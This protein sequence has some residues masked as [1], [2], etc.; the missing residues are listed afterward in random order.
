VHLLFSLRFCTGAWVPAAACQIFAGVQCDL[1][2][3]M[4]EC[5]I[6][7]EFYSRCTSLQSFF[8]QL[9]LSIKWKE[10]I[11]F[12]RKTRP[13]DMTLAWL[14][15]GKPAENPNIDSIAKMKPKMTQPAASHRCTSLQSSISDSN[16]SFC[17]SLTCNIGVYDTDTH[18]NSNPF[19]FS[20]PCWQHSLIL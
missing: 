4:N 13:E 18:V 19:L 10:L 11:R 12:I 20:V 2:I 16:F 15:K 5:F 17:E 7:S 3:L 6:A 1:D 9:Y 14:I 8:E